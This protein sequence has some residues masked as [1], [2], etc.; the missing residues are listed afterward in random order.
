MVSNTG[1]GVEHATVSRS[2]RTEHVGQAALVLGALSIVCVVVPSTRELAWVLALPTV[3]LAVGAL[4]VGLGR[5][6]FATAALLLGWFA[7]AYSF[8]FMLWG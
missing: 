2:T 5:K 1:D 3:A 8:A 6:R 4:G 7:F